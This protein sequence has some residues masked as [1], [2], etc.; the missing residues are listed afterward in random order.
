MIASYSIA[1]ISFSNT[2]VL[3]V[4]TLVMFFPIKDHGG[5]IMD[6]YRIFATSGGSYEFD[7]EILGSLNAST[8]VIRNLLYWFN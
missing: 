7:M 5:N 8:A 4:S 1:T 3:I 6:V 2:S